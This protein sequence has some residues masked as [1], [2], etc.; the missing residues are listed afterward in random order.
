MCFFDS[1]YITDAEIL[2]N[3]KDV[4]YQD[5]KFSE[6]ASISWDG[7]NPLIINH[8]LFNN[9]I[10]NKNLD[11]EHTTFDS[12]IF[13][14]TSKNVL[15]IGNLAITHCVINSEFVL[16]NYNIENIIID[17]SSFDSTVSIKYNIV[18]DLTVINTSFYKPADMF[19]S[20]FEKFN[21][22]KSEF[23]DFAGFE[24]C[25]YGIKDSTDKEY[26]SRFTYSTFHGLTNFRGTKFYN[27]ID[28]KNTNLI[29]SPNFLNAYISYNNS[30]RESFRIIKYSFDKIGNHIEA[31]KYYVYEM[32]KYKEE[33]SWKDQ[34][35][36]RLLLWLNEKISDYGQ[37]YLKPVIFMLV[38]SIIYSFVIF[39]YENNYIYIFSPSVN[40]II[41]KISNL[42]N[43]ISKNI[44]PFS[45]ILKN[46][47]EFI[48]LIFY[49]I[50]IVFI[51][52]T[53]VAIKRHTS[54]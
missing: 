44:I 43:S 21:I 23:F 22:T 30:N 27:G 39:G 54:R 14:N 17:S 9:C 49:L 19:Q 35:Q 37:S 46:G 24:K 45:K 16:N 48:S 2:G 8:Q 11:F 18:K 5:C 3:V 10:F 47:M 36:K 15:S 51:W 53:I 28:I 25:I 42:L 50:F 20:K 12:K 4:I 41:E 38:A 1:Q 26:L 33:L 7:E 13:N 34:K 29:E 6:N 32:Q 52:Q 31:N 40:S